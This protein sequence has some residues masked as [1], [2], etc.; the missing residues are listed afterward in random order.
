MQRQAKQQQIAQEVQ[1]RILAANTNP[2]TEIIREL[3]MVIQ[4]TMPVP[5]APPR[6]NDL[7]TA[8]EQAMANQ[9]H[10]LGKALEQM[11][12]SLAEFVKYMKE[13]DK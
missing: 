8:F 13:K 7:I 12:M 3:Q 9:N 10:Q 4:P 11:G 5:Q 6:H 1:N 2:Q